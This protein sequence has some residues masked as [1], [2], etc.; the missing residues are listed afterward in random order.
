MTQTTKNPV[1]NHSKIV[2]AQITLPQRFGDMARVTAKMSDGSEM[3]VFEYFSDE[4]HFTAEEFE[5]LT[6]DQ[7]CELKFRK[8]VA[9]LRS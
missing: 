5:G 6:I 9:Y 4:L 7:A 2:S 8:D 1:V 3:M